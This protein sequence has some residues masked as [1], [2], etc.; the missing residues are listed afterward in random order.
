MSDRARLLAVARGDARADL[1]LSNGRV[2]NV[3]TGEVLA[4]EVALVDGIIA[5]VGETRQGQE[6]I[7]LGGR[8]VVP[9]LIDAHVHLESSLLTPVEF[10]RTVV[11]R[12][13]TTVLCDPHELA[14]VAGL[15]GIQWLLAASEGLPLEVLVNAPSCV[16]ATH[17]ASAGAE[18]DAAALASLR[19]HPRVIGLGEVMNVPGAVLGDA[20]VLTKID[21]FAGAPVDGHAPGLEGGWLNAYLAAGIATDHE[22]VS[23]EEAR[24]KLRLGMRVFLRQA[25]GARNLV[26]LLP[27]ITPATARRCALC[28][29]DRHPHDLLDEGHIDHL[30][31]LAIGHGLDAV[32]AVQLAT[33]NAAEAFGLADRGAIAPGR[34]ADLVVCSELEGFRAD[35]VF[36]RGR[37]VAE[38]GEPAGD[39]GPGPTA[40]HGALRGRM[41]VDLDAIDLGLPATAASARVIGVVRGQIVTE[42]LVAT[43]PV[44]EGQLQAAPERDIVK[45]AVIERHAG[46]GRVGL[47]LVHGLG[48]RRGALASTV[49]HDH[50]NLMLAGADDTSMRTAAAAVIDSGGG[51][52]VAH[53]EQVLALLELPIGGL[54]SDLPAAEVRHRLEQLLTSAR[55][56]GSELD[57]PFMTMSFLGL[58]VIPALKLTDRGLVDVERFEL[59]PLA[60][61]GELTEATPDH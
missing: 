58:E 17:L 56:L 14:N 45:L 60:M 10:A 40:D 61:D 37:L 3:F 48:L 32:T 9:G 16:P 49:V 2:V 28:S 33:L 42:S 27:A 41:R 18:L 29:D 43:L 34:R 50:H 46:S 35:L 26:D 30:L 23:A 24:A 15:D 21:A 11:P 31:R 51:L 54:V 25:T 57:D 20:A 19:P 4:A 39:W 55:T 53:G 13:T 12:G 1:V 6:V 38:G 44:A 8:Y 52:A 5:S 36:S 7:D 59:V 47:G 22:C